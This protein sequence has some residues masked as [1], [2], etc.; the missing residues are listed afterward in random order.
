MRRTVRTATA[1]A[2]AAAAVMLP[3]TTANAV[4]RHR[5]LVMNMNW[6]NVNQQAGGDIFNAGRDNNVGSFN[7]TGG[8]TGVGAP[9]TTVPLTIR[10]QTGAVLALVSSTGSSTYPQFLGPHSSTLVEAASVSSASYLGNVSV[11]FHVDARLLPP[12]VCDSGD[13]QVQ[14]GTDTWVLTVS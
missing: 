12:V 7:G 6:N 3:L 14:L 11:A 2:T 13:C 1:L 10:N 9:V 4:D 5:D 8:D